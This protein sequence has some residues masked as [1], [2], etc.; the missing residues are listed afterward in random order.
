MQAAAWLGVLLFPKL[1]LLL[2]TGGSGNFPIILELSC[3]IP[4]GMG[5]IIRKGKTIPLGNAGQ[6]IRHHIQWKRLGAPRPPSEA[7]LYPRFPWSQH[8]FSW[9]LSL[10]SWIPC[11]ALP[12][13]VPSSSDSC[14]G[15]G[16]LFVTEQREGEIG[17]RG[18]LG[19][20]GG[21][22]LGLAR[23]QPCHSLPS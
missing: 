9:S 13:K 19:W 20:L 10:P 3:I 8:R 6:G 18:E 11:P 14:G 15:A 4:A 16:L 23:S 2:C 22:L 12:C 17:R 7:M 5:K 1:H 21:V